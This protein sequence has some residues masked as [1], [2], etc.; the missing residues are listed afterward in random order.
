MPEWIKITTD[1]YLVLSRLGAASA[2]SQL[3]QE[4]GHLH[5]V[6]DGSEG[7]GSWETHPGQ[8]S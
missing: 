2:V 8:P 1:I 5:S 7:W 6:D 3:C 4:L